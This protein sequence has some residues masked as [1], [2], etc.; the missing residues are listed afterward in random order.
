MTANPRQ[1]GQNAK[2]GRPIE[3]VAVSANPARFTDPA[4]VEKHFVPNYRPWQQ[5]LAFVPDGDLFAGIRDIEAANRWLQETYLPR[6]NAELRKEPALPESGFVKVAHERLV[7]TLCIEETRTV[8]R[9][10]TIA[11]DGRRLQIPESPMRRHYVGATVKVHHYPDGTTGVL[12]GPRVIARYDRDGKPIAAS[13][14]PVGKAPKQTNPAASSVAPRSVP[15][16]CGLEASAPASPPACRPTLTA[17]ARVG[18]SL[19]QR[20]G[21][22]PGRQRA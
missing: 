22:S 19:C 9:D 11:W 12:H 16:R 14:A 7:E 3:P 10:N 20:L 2:T 4:T 6:H 1:P 5:R 8:G 13:T 18:A 21:R 15:S 17:S